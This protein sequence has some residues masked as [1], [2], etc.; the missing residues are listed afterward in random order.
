MTTDGGGWTIIQKRLDGEVDFY[1]TWIEYKNGFGNASKNYW[2]GNDAIHAL[3]KNGN[4][5]LRIELQ[6][7]NGEKA[8]AQYSTF[9]LGSEDTFYKLNVSGYSGTAG[10]SLAYHNNKRFATKD[11]EVVYSGRYCAR[12]RHGAWWYYT[13]SYS[14]LN[15]KYGDVGEKGTEYMVWHHWTGGESLKESTMMIRETQ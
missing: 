15:G 3:T 9:S 11:S 4:Q 6:R 7:F 5:T 8:F 10:N 2:I 14:N 12:G 13:C 1:R